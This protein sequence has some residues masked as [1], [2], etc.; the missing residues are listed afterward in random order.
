VSVPADP[1]PAVPAV[2]RLA[3]LVLA[4]EAAGVVTLGLVDGFKVVTGSPRSFGLAVVGALL[5][6]GTGAVLLLLARAVL[7]TRGW[8]FTPA[9]VLQGLALPVGYSLAVQAGRW[10]YGGPILLLAIAALCLLLAPA[11]RRALVTP[12]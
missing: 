2:L 7:R 9:L 8:A 3:A 1:P 12:R 10:Y 11:S 6:L 4:A 5:A